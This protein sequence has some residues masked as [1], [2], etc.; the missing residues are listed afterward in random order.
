[1]SLK[2]FVSMGECSVLV[3]CNVI[4]GSRANGTVA[5][6]IYKNFLWCPLEKGL[7]ANHCTIL[8]QS[9]WVTDQNGR[10]VD[11]CRKELTMNF[12]VTKI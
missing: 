10:E 12:N 5:P 1:M 9:L 7:L 2:V 8:S 3:H 4:E 6:V 11:F